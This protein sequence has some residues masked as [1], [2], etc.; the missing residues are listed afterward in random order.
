MLRTYDSNGNETFDLKNHL[1]NSETIKTQS[2]V[3]GEWNLNIADNMLEIGNYRYRPNDS[4][5][6]FYTL[7]NTFT[8]ETFNINGTAKYYG[9]TDADV[10]IDGGYDNDNNPT[11]ILTT[12]QKN[13]FYYSLEDC[14]DRFR[15]RSG[16]NKA[17]NTGDS[18]IRRFGHFTDANMA[19]RPRYYVA[20]KTNIFKYWTSFRPDV[21]NGL[22][23]DRGISKVFDQSSTGYY[24]QDA[25]PFIIYKN[26]I[27]ANRIIVKMQTHV[28]DASA[29]TLNANG[30]PWYGDD[31][32]AVPKKW[33]IQV[34]RKNNTS[35]LTQWTSEI[36]LSSYT[37][38]NDGYVELVYGPQI[39]TQYKD[40]FTYIATIA[41]T[42]ALP[43]SSTNGYAYLVESDNKYR[44][45]LNSS[46]IEFTASSA[47]QPIEKFSNRNIPYAKDL[48]GD[49]TS[50]ATFNLNDGF[51][52]YREFD[53][54]QGIRI[55]VDT[56]KKQKTSFDLIE[57]SPRLSVDLSDKTLDF[58][59][60]KKASD[61]STS[62][63]PLGDIL[64][65][66]G[67]L[68]LF[69]YDQAFDKNNTNSI[70]KDISFKNLQFKF[71]QKIIDVG[72]VDYLIPIK[73]MYSDGFPDASYTD[74]TL[75]VTLRDL[76]FYFES[77]TAPTVFIKNKTLSYIVC[78]LLDSI[79]YSNY[80]FKRTLDEKEKVIPDFF[81]APDKTVSEIL[82][83][84]AKSTQASMF[85][86]EENNFVV[87]SKNYMMPSYTTNIENG[88]VTDI[89][90]S[91]STDQKQNTSP[92]ESETSTYSGASIANI[93][94]IKAENHD[95]YNDG[96]IVYDSRY[97]QKNVSNLD[98]VSKLDSDKVYTYQPVL[99]WELAEQ[100]DTNNIEKDTNSGYLL[101]AMT[102]KTQISSSI[103][104]VSNNSIVNNT[105]DVGESVY[106]LTNYSGYVFANGEIIKYDAKQYSLI[107]VPNVTTVWISS[108]SDKD[109]YF[110]KVPYN[111]KMYPTGLIRVYTEVSYKENGDLDEVIRHGRGQF[112][113]KI[114]SHSA[115]IPTNSPW[116]TNT[117]GA[118]ND[119][120]YLNGK[121]TFPPMTTGAT[122]VEIPTLSGTT[123]IPAGKGVPTSGSFFY[124]DNSS[125]T[126]RTGVIRNH[127]SSVYPTIKQYNETQSMTG[128]VQASALTISGNRSNARTLP[129]NFL[130]YSYKDL[131]KCN[132]TFGTRMRIMGQ[133]TNDKFVT[134]SATGSMAYFLST[135]IGSEREEN[136]TKINIV[137]GSGGIAIFLNPVSNSGYYFEISALSSYES[138]SDYSNMWFYKLKRKS[139]TGIKTNN[140]GEQV[141]ADFS[142]D[143]T[144]NLLKAKEVGDINTNTQFSNTLAVGD[145]VKI[146]GQ[147]VG[148]INGYYLINK[149]GNQ[150]TKWEMVR[151]ELAIPELLWRG[152]NKILVDSTGTVG[153]SRI[154][155][156]DESQVY[157]LKVTWEDINDNTAIRFSLYFNDILVG[158][159]VDDK[160]EV[161]S[162]N[163][164]LF[165][166][167][168]SK[169]MFEHVYA[170]SP[171]YKEKSPTSKSYSKIFGIDN[172]KISDTFNAYRLNE[173]II[174]DY[175]SS[176]TSTGFENDLYFEEFGTILRECAYFN[177]RYDKA[178]P[179]L[180]AK[181]ANNYNPLLGYYVSNFRA[182]PYGAE[183][184][185]FNTTDSPLPMD[186]STGNYLRISGITFTAESKN[187]LTVDDFFNKT[188]DYSHTQFAGL[189]TNATNAK[190]DSLLIKN[191]RLTYGKKDFSLD[192]T[193][194][195]DRDT[196]YEM[197][198]WMIQK[199]K[200]PKIA[201]GVE[202]FGLPI[203]Q[204]GD[205]VKINYHIT[206]IKDGTTTQDNIQIP[207]NS[208]FVVY[209]INHSVNT[210]GPSQ[211]LYLSEVS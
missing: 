189:P 57:L 36:D 47:W 4:Q 184:M 69:D 200:K 141:N 7:P 72:G 105:I 96:K 210:D 15:P 125:F 203:I 11:S 204:L 115:G 44:M 111:G 135:D 23:V 142:G 126:K 134:Q 124:E 12:N 56:M 177:I 145:R 3:V 32:K 109:Y 137:G 79:G 41:N 186:S 84:L 102:L 14:F 122:P 33:S 199:I 93:I 62:G 52:R 131:G 154:N 8:K 108:Q 138:S 158:V 119:F 175:L 192:A 71:Y 160:P 103:P 133:L 10:I 178:Y 21:E 81:I 50:L 51:T 107:G 64:A 46:W 202:V 127:L 25:V 196:A 91:A 16:I 94:D 159:C 120:E 114:I 167:G 6:S 59:I 100:N 45:W 151:D 13:K 172:I 31:D 150:T 106:W 92:L 89:T 2:L 121:K 148:E 49:E 104:S 61:L 29:K 24:I 101:S 152:K 123:T 206:K 136:L 80:I 97:I 163:V 129:V 174:T 90:L 164:G 85:F 130:S 170:L 146:S 185:V 17:V 207:E 27:Y 39:L 161:K 58:S 99:L 63:L 78:M 73:T 149:L 54:I 193:Y 18:S 173:T 9:A 194:I 22:P 60:D 112:G 77:T 82:Q 165:V 34:L 95:V 201:I 205:I 144:Q 48:V 28:G 171:N 162:N 197:M 208:R 83:D 153:L 1:L 139:N 157:D 87:M 117:A 74:R 68:S 75:D 66:T 65:S 179:A 113:T 198:N 30:D 20:D 180:L 166:R 86:D 35:G 55:V 42:S 211:T 168:T 98:Q 26:N 143:T 155:P 116:F 128:A 183:F 191:S 140:S 43:T 76:F 53:L 70:L 169:C 118:A 190:N 38:N 156:K 37:I 19:K 5:S 147:N 209:A 182:T 67:K 188:S 110:S 187:E 40:I 88:R 181:I 132:Q 195:Q 176:Q